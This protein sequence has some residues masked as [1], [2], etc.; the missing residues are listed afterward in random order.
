[1]IRGIIDAVTWV[2][3]GFALIALL[4]ASFGIINTLLMAVQERTR[5]IGLMKAL[6]MTG[7]RIFGLF[8]LEAVMIG[9]L[10]SLIGIGLGVAVG[11][12]ANALLTQGALSGVTGLVLYAVEPL[13]LLLIALLILAIAFLAGTLPAARAARK[14]P[15]EALRYE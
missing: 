6:G 8:T 5:E 7:G 4:A 9:L 3:N 12:T 14:D 1:V 13:S 11:L 2:L 10:G 15:I